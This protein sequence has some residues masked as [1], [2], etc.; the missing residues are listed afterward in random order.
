MAAATTS[1]C[2]ECGPSGRRACIECCG[3][4]YCLT[5]LHCLR[6]ASHPSLWKITDKSEYSRTLLGVTEL[7]SKIVAELERDLAAAQHSLDD[8]V[9][10]AQ[11]QQQQQLKSFSATEWKRRATPRDAP[12]PTAAPNSIAQI[13][14]RFI[15]N[16]RAAATAS[17]K[18]VPVHSRSSNSNSTID[19]QQHAVYAVDLD[20]DELESSS[21]PKR[22]RLSPSFSS[23]ALDG[24]ASLPIESIE[25]IAADSDA[26]R[27]DGDAAT[28]ND[29]VIRNDSRSSAT[30]Q[31]ENEKQQQGMQGAVP[32]LA[33]ADDENESAKAAATTTTTRETTSAAAFAADTKLRA[34]AA[35]SAADAKLRASVVDVLARSFTQGSA[36]EVAAAAP[37]ARGGDL[38]SVAA[39]ELAR[40]IVAQTHTSRTFSRQIEEAILQAYSG[41]TGVG[42][43]DRA[44]ALAHALR[45]NH[46]LRSSILSGDVPPAACATMSID[47]L[48]TAQ[49]RAERAALME[50][51]PLPG[52]TGEVWMSSTDRVCPGCGAADAEYKPTS[53]QRDIRKAEIWGSSS[54]GDAR[55]C[56]RCKQCGTEWERTSI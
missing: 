47:D 51:G 11:K 54:D 31:E 2:A 30:L 33:A 28:R 27:T 17:H 29:T 52:G 14:G 18:A 37:A 50:S 7:R 46:A 36:E 38:A 9:S 19:E 3:S 49:E 22:Q 48:A 13:R 16:A 55:Y 32:P 1:S 21:A 20:S 44:R 41:D 10:R 34:S 4:P 43:R 8:E 24:S 26:G 39:R 56:F 45:I 23:D 12:A 35:A 42:Y 6:H 40:P 53:Q 25:S 5:C 15:A